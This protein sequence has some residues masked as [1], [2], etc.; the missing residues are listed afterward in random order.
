VMQRDAV[1]SGFPSTA[2]IMGTVSSSEAGP[3]DAS[4]RIAGG[5]ISLDRPRVMGILNATP[6]SFWDGGRFAAVDAALRHVEKM[7]ADG[8]DLIDVGG[9]STRPGARPVPAADEMARVLPVLRACRREWPDLPISV[10]TVKSVVAVAALGDGA[11]AINDVS[12]FRLDPDM[13]RVC[14]EGRAGVVLMHSRGSVAEMASYHTAVYGADP[15]GDVASELGASAS[16]ARAAGVAADAIVLDPGLGFSKR[17][18]HSVA[19]IGG[20]DR[21]LALGYP[22][23][24]GPSRKRFVGDLAG[25]ATSEERLPGTIAACVVGWLRG[26]RLFRVHDVGAVRAALQVAHSLAG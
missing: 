5:S 1:G 11:S 10:D 12:A 23:L 26:A 21:I 24:L 9:E 25:G 22:V 8:A 14:A 18:A 15:A 19:V 17:T 16:A 3:H 2:D 20:L 13:A 6:D 4:W 7:V